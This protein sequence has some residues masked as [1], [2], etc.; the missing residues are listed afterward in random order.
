MYPSDRT[1]HVSGHATDHPIDR[2]AD[3]HTV[4]TR[5]GRSLGKAAAMLNA[6]CAE[7]LDLH[8]T[9]WECVGLLLDT[10]PRPQTAG[11]LAAQT[12]LT[13]GAITGVLDRLE[14]KAWVRRERDSEDRRRV[15][16]RLLPGRRA[17]IAAILADMHEDMRALQ[18]DYS[19]DVLEAC[20]GLLF[21]ASEI[22]RSYALTLRAQDAGER[23]A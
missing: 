23:E 6:A 21:G 13:T 18:A 9:E 2:R 4:L 8:T 3:L 19:E 15:I 10:D 1:D 7:R 17:R 5:A 12:G 14:A 16:V 20:A 11:E 22:L